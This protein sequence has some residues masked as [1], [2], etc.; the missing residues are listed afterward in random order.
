MEAQPTTF[1][2]NEKYHLGRLT[3]YQE[4]EGIDINNTPQGFSLDYPILIKDSDHNKLNTQ[5]LNLLDSFNVA[6]SSSSSSSTDHNTYE[7]T[8]LDETA[9]NQE[10]LTRVYSCDY[11]QR[12]FFSWQ[13]LGGH[14]NAHKQERIVEK[15]DRQRRLNSFRY[16]HIRSNHQLT[17]NRHN[18][19]SSMASLPPF[20]GSLNNNSRPISS[21]SEFVLPSFRFNA[22]NDH[23]NDWLSSSSSRL[24]L[25]DDQQAIFQLPSFVHGT[26]QHFPGINDGLIGGNSFLFQGGG[27]LKGGCSDKGDLKKI[28]LALK[29]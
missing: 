21:V 10:E 18:R 19:F 13:A 25:M 6:G 24:P 26:L 5:E 16:A 23:H 20:H 14:Q 11:C 28:D 7:E 9:D 29:L 1:S 2:E 4:E 15:R 8:E 3:N 22:Q 27:P 12:K 17:Y